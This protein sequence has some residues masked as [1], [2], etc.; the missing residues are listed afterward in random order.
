M[1]ELHN[2]RQLRA[3]EIA[4][5]LK[6]SVATIKRDLDALRAARRIEFLGPSK[7]G[8]YRLKQ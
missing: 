3:P 2:G 6:C 8:Y 1:T 5:E 7:T 4:G